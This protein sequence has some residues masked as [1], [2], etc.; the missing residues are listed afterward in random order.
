MNVHQRFPG[1]DALDAFFKVLSWMLRWTVALRRAVVQQKRPVGEDLPNPARKKLEKVVIG[2]D[3]HFRLRAITDK[4]EA[5]RRLKHM[6][7]SLLSIFEARG[8]LVE[9]FSPDVCLLK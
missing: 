5:A 2:D 3:A 6:E 7:R 8:L 4:I 9:D 1:P